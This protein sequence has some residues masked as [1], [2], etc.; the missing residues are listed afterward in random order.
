[1]IK[2][3]ATEV[4]IAMQEF[5]G[6]ALNIILISLVIVLLT[7]KELLAVGAVSGRRV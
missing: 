1:M 6:T 7:L 3:V 2:L 5:L 4:C